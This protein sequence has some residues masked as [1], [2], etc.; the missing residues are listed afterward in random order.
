M[1]SSPRYVVGIDL[2]TTNSVVAY[3]DTQS[4][5]EA[6]IELLAIPQLTAAGSIEAL[7]NLNSA[8]YVAA[9]GEFPAEALQL[10]WDS[11]PAQIVGRFAQKRGAEVPS[12][13]INSAKSW[14]SY[15]EANRREA[16][17]P[18][19]AP[20]EIAKLS[21][22]EASAAF[23]GHLH[24][25]WDQAFPD[26][27]LADQEVILTVPASFDAVARELSVEAAESAGIDGVIV[28][29][30]PQ[31]AFY[32]WVDTNGEQWR[33]HVGVG[34][35]VLVCDIGGG[36]TDLTLISVEQSGGELKLERTAVGDHILLGGDNMD[37]ALA[38]AQREVIQSAGSKIDDWQFRSLT[39]ACREA[40][41]Q[42]LESE[43]VE[44]FAISI[45]GRGSSLIGSTI[46]SDI[47][48]AQTNQIVLD[49]FFPQSPLDEK[50]KRQAGGGL[51]E[52]ALPYASDPAI[53]R[54]IADFLSRQKN[55]LQPTAILFNGGVT[56]AE[57]LRK[58]LVEVVDSWF[59]DSDGIRV[60][61]G[62]DPENGVARG[63]AYYGLARRGSGIRIHGGTARSYYIGVESSMPS[64][65]GIR[66]PI[67]ALCV[68][69]KGIEEG[70]EVELPPQEFGLLVGVK[71][72]FRF[73]SS[74]IRDEDAVGL[75][76]DE[77]DQEN[78][79]IEEVEPLELM[80]DGA[81]D[82][83]EMVPVRL[84]ARVTELGIL[85]IWCVSRDDDRRWKLEFNVR[86]RD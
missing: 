48:R 79:E 71:A 39:L 3:I 46:R 27:P 85:E 63:A 4:G 29:E 82:D 68:A 60:L 64:V 2:G 30:E 62:A 43:Q 75:L 58:R 25:A 20:E 45:L 32:A 21:P 18:W 53:T 86:Q 24:Q 72:I 7:P 22:L 38:F 14:L 77:W 81:N 59:P 26:A 15:S 55:A 56:R 37:L 47:Q 51:Q 49:G 83:E 5:A 9:E 44:S 41:E 80:I 23:L 13:L 73:L 1:N 84:Q 17:L 31:A 28:I 34:D 40:K 67:K 69:P 19:G 52:M 35:L 74:S 42:L 6:S 11:N 33:E 8:L 12:R 61:A 70:S 10:P 50:P 78:G 66:P 57:V 36:T 76:I 16:L 65:P 54:H